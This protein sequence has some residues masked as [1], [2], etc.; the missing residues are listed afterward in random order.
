MFNVGRQAAVVAAFKLA[1]YDGDLVVAPIAYETEH[2]FLLDSD[3]FEQ[4]PDR[5]ALEHVLTQLLARK[6]WVAM[7]TGQWGGPVPF[8]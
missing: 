3:A 5:R 4:L 6:V 1:G 2:A 8:E 7:R